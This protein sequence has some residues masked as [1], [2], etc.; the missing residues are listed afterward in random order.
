VNG[1]SRVWIIPVGGGEPQ[2]LLLRYA[3]LDGVEF[4]ATESDAWDVISTAQ[5]AAYEA[6]V[7]AG[8]KP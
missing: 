6:R 8:G 1:S 7:K 2:P 3:I 5:E 4:Y